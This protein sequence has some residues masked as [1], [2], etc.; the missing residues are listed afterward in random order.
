MFKLVFIFHTK[1]NGAQRFAMLV[2]HVEDISGKLKLYGFHTYILRNLSIRES[3]I[4]TD[5]STPST[6]ISNE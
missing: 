2:E 3:I 5:W 6:D 4:S 1:H